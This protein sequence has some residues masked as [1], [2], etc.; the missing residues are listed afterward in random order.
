M[1]R[2]NV[3]KHLHAFD[4]KNLFIDELGWANPRG[5]AQQTV[6]LDDKTYTFTPIAQLSGVMVFEVVPTLEGGLIPD[7]K[8]RDAAHKDLEKTHYEHLLIFVD[9]QRSQSVWSWRK[10]DNKKRVRREHTYIKGQPGDLFLGKLDS[11]M[12]DLDDLRPDGTIPISE[13]TQRLAAALDIER[14]TKKFYTEFSSLRV[15]FINQIQGIPSDKDRFWYAS[16]LLNRLMFVY[17][18]QKRFFIQNNANYLNEKLTDS[19]RQGE[20]RFYSK[21]LHALFFEGF[22]KPEGQRTETAKRLIGEIRYLN[23]GLFLKHKLEL[24][25][26][27]IQIPDTAFDDVLALF[28]RYSWHLD[29]ALGVADNEINP[30]VL[31]YI[32]EKYINQK[33]FGAYY[34]RPQITEY[35]CERTIHAVIL[36]K[37]AVTDKRYDS[38]G[39][40]LLRLDADL[41]RRMLFEVLP[42]LSI[43]DPACGSGAF[44]V[45]AM[46]TLLDVYSAVLGKIEFL[47]DLNLIDHLTMIR[48]DHP[49]INYY[50]RKRIITDNLYG[51]DIME[52]AT[53]IAKLRL[54]LVLVSS[55]QKVEQLEPLPNIDFNLMHGN[56]LIGLQEVRIERIIK[57]QSS[58]IMDGKRFNATGHQKE[59]FQIDN[60]SDYE[61][62]LIRKN[63]LINEYRDTS[64]LTNDL[65]DLRR[66]IEEQQTGAYVALDSMLLDDFQALGIKYEQVGADGKTTKRPVAI[67]DI[68][69]LTPFHWGYEFDQI[70]G[71]GGFDVVIANPP[72][73]VFK[74]IDREFARRYDPEVDRRLTSKEVFD[75]R[76]KALLD[77]SPKIQQG[78]LDYLSSFPY[79]SAYYRDEDGAYPYQISTV[80]GKKAGT[81]INLYKLFTELCFRLLREAGECGL[82]IPS[83]I[84]SDLGTKRLR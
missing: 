43:L 16:V 30:D 15:D 8:V 58:I 36:E 68:T 64:S 41:C 33:A 29:D 51:V 71:R 66:L 31:G 53:E 11:M 49:S 78:Y 10:R 50:I 60:A 22:A 6:A 75:A 73:E 20:N 42:T 44:L 54:F 83:G 13:V 34:T 18:M 25:N 57:H 61:D 3:R 9:S 56:S 77:G 79:V 17:F 63:E 32:F 62:L 38:V 24:E 45:A 39:E 28:G 23:G 2:E 74:P 19:R 40:L 14:V 69:T 5:Q 55:A 26:Q 67:S 48:R 76:F 12:V 1:N 27:D 84:Y 37:V 21:F 80:N 82:V 7:T 72:W 4:F 59:M 47:S 52:E 65:Q 46:K 35:L 70:M 81:D